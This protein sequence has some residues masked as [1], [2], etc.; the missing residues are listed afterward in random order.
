MVY[1]NALSAYHVLG[2]ERRGNIAAS[3]VRLGRL[4]FIVHTYVYHD[5]YVQWMPR[6][7]YGSMR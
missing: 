3:M 1:D 5:N 6:E 4:H 2:N 7:G